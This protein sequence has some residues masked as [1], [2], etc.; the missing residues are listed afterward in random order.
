MNGYE[1]IVVAPDMSKCP[2]GCIR[3][4]GLAFDRLGRLFVTSDESGEVCGG[5]SVM[6]IISHF[7]VA[8]GFRDSELEQGLRVPLMHMV[9]TT[10][11]LS[12]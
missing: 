8:I 7:V 9:L 6:D 2:S 3:P 1:T 5:G 4:V 12:T 11:L 10:Q